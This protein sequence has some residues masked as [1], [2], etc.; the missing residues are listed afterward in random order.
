VST[1]KLSVV[2]RAAIAK[3]AAALNHATAEVTSVEQAANV[4]SQTL[5]A[6]ITENHF[7]LAAYA[8]EIA[9]VAYSQVLAITAHLD[10]HNLWG[11]R[12]SEEF[13][14]DYPTFEDAVIAAIVATISDVLTVAEDYSAQITVAPVADS[15]LNADT[16][17]ADMAVALEDGTVGTYFA[18]DYSAEDYNAAENSHQD[19]YYAATE[20]STQ[21]SVVTGD[22]VA[23][24]TGVPADD[25]YAVG[26]AL[27][28]VVNAPVADTS[29][30]V[31]MT[32]ST[33]TS[34]RGDS[35]SASDLVTAYLQV[36]LSD[37]AAK[38][39]F[40][41]DYAV[42]DYNTAENSHEDAWTSTTIAT[43]VSDTFSVVEST[44]VSNTS[45]SP[46][47]NFTV[48]EVRACD[49]TSTRADTSVT[50]DSIGASVQ[51]PISDTRSSTDVAQAL[52]IPPTWADEAIPIDSI[53]IAITAAAADTA[54]H[55]DAT[56]A[57][58]QN[59]ALD[60]TYFSE[61]YATTPY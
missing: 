59:Y 4:I 31:D 42:E 10:E 18:A 9:G 32:S 34:L 6:E 37:G 48:V 12:Y 39:Y 2:V 17:S 57:V 23:T 54:T 35:A 43:M 41:G 45:S 51:A 22:S 53:A 40:A 47:D 29:V 56:S 58:I 33:Q 15:A 46:A 50:S 25:V 60:Y 55:A 24:D 61:D 14:W 16:Y 21:D 38:T 36:P 44:P 5:A 28:A 11:I 7:E 49:I 8:Q 3:A 1:L 52:W 26:D 30:T 13:H 19:A 27:S 20:T